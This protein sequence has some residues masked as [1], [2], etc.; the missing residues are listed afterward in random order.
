VDAQ[1]IIIEMNKIFKH[2]ALDLGYDELTAETKKSGRKYITPFGDEYPSITTVLGYRDRG[3]WAKWRKDIGEEN[4][5]KITR[6]ATGRGTSVHNIAERYINNEETIF[7]TQNDKMPHIQFSWNVLKEA[8][9]SYIGKVYMQ[10]CTLYS[11]KLK[12]AGRVDCVADYDNEIAIVDF[13]TS[14]RIKT[15]DE[16]ENYFMQECAYAIMF[17]EHTGIRIDNLVTIMVA[18]EN[19]KPA[20]FIQKRKAWEQRLKDEIK[21]YYDHINGC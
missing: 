9:D 11:D 12:V 15:E 13:K 17:E 10:E 7:K 21:Y 1:L 8:I 16:I 19:P 3:K 14:G 2:V 4:A 5:N 20:I 6:R 18:D